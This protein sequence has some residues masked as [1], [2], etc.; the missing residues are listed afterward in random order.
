LRPKPISGLPLG[1]GRPKNAR[2]MSPETTE[3]TGLYEFLAW[4][5]ANKKRLMLAAVAVLAA[6]VA[7]I[8]YSYFRDR[9][10]AQA[11]ESLLALRALPSA[12]TGAKAAS[13]QEFLRVADDYAS[14][15]AGER[16]LLL[17]AGNLFTDGNYAEA[18]AQFEKFKTSFG[19]SPL[20]S[21]AALG[22]ASS[23]DA[24]D[25]VD[26]ALAAYQDVA[27]NYPDDP[28]AA[29]AKLAMASI[30]ETKKQPEQELKVLDELS[31]KPAIYG[32]AAVEAMMRK[33]Q[34]LQQ[35]P[36]LARTNVTT[37]PVKL[38]GAATNTS[39]LAPPAAAAKAK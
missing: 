21:I 5:E 1:A 7:L 18:Q 30:Y 10:E 29:H 17:A 12:S 33:E 37:A 19:S 8:V 16:A 36:D 34:L 23:L 28:V 25:K 35:Y 20:V 15:S 9:R 4:A 39:N 14:T 22:V 31:S 13:P 32:D 26:A 11:S 24:Q 2:F 38:G 6:I 3:S 27:I